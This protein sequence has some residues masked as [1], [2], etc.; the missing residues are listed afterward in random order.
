[1]KLNLNSLIE[2]T[3]IPRQISLW[4]AEYT[5]FTYISNNGLSYPELVV[6]VIKPTDY[7]NY[8][9]NE[10][11]GRWLYILSCSGWSSK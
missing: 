2:N 4:S 3:T 5:E 8:F 10:I 9:V 6:L 1:M 11:E 7:D